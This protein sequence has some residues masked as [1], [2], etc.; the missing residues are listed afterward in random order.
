[1]PHAHDLAVIGPRR[2]LEVRGHRVR[3][4]HQRVVARRRERVRQVREDAVTVVANLG[5]LAVHLSLGSGDRTAEGL[6]DR[7]MSEAYAE[8]RRVLAEAPDDLERHSGVVRGAGAG[9]DHDPLGR[10]RSD[11]VGVYGIVADHVQLGAE[12]AEILHEVVGEGVVVV[13]DEDHA[14]DPA[15]AMRSARMS[16]RALEHVSSHSVLGSESATIPAPTWIDAR[17]PW[18]TIVRIVMQESRLPEYET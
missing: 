7:L 13:D 18:H 4:Y 5:C 8:D 17:L 15:A 6:A 12:L 1:M 9:R 11:A 3:Q 16:P 10:E 14:R 2:D